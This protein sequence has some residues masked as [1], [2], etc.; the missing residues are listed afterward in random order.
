MSKVAYRTSR[1]TSLHQLRKLI[2]SIDMICTNYDLLCFGWNQ[3]LGSSA[4]PSR[5]EL[6]LF[7]LDHCLRSV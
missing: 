3:L 7:D 5:T 6:P 1:M 4:Y 2:S